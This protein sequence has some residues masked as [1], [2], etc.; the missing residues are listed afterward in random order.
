MKLTKGFQSRVL[1]KES[2]AKII[3]EDK[4]VYYSDMHLGTLGVADETLMT[5]HLIFHSL[6]W[7][8]DNGYHLV[9]LGD[10]FEMAENPNIEEIKNAHDDIMWLFSEFYKNDKLTIV[11]G[12][13]EEYLKEKD[14][15]YRQ[16]NYNGKQIE[17]LPNI[18]IEKSVCDKSIWA[19][20]GNEYSFS[21]STWLNKII[22]KLGGL[23]KWWQLSHHDYHISESTGW[24]KAEKIDNAF[25][26]FARIY[27]GHIIAGHTHKCNFNLPHYTNT[28]SCGVMPRCI[29][30]VEHIGDKVY[31]I[32]WAENVESDGTMKVER[33]I[34]GE[35]EL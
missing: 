2:T 27:G 17:F 29:T 24:E 12:N 32:K 20:H 18:K 21:Y 14:L 22:V 35:Q 5:K 7:Y 9:L 4:V 1:D 34:L 33:T 16:S 6:K 11:R 15:Y 25:N 8:F 19:L 23:W 30:G 13:H 31:T 10:T 3:N 26:E 28:G